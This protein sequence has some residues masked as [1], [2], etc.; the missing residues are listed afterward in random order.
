MLASLIAL[1]LASLFSPP[2]LFPA[3]EETVIAQPP[4]PPD[5][6]IPEPDLAAVAAQVEATLN[7]GAFS[8]TRISIPSLAID[9]PVIEV[10]VNS[11]GEMD[12]PDG[13]TNLVGWYKY[14]TVPGDVGSAVMDAHVY[15]AFKR[16]KSAQIGS[17]IF[18][19]DTNGTVREFKIVSSKVYPLR[20][21]PMRTIFS[22]T[23]GMYLN[24]ITCEGRYLIPKGTYD[25]RRVVYAELVK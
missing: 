12:V 22:D 9:S 21:V 24:L 19:T 16:L 11:A 2:E 15:A 14:G 8:P 17:S 13:S 18:V 5:T 7:P 23:S 6:S 4:L 1:T 3:P 10:G 25:K 20:E